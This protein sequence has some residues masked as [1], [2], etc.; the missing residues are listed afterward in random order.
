M[1]RSAL[2]G[3]IILGGVAAA[4]LFVPSL[5][6]T[7]ATANSPAAR[8]AEL[9]R[10][11]LH[12]YS[13]ELPH[14][15]DL[16]SEEQLK[17]ADLQA[18]IEKY[19]ETFAQA[20]QQMREAQQAAKSRDQ[21]AGITDSKYDVPN[22]TG[23][24]MKSAVDG[25]GKLVQLN[26]K[27][28]KDAMSLAKNAAQNKQVVG[29]SNVLG[30][31]EYTHAVQAQLKADDLRT[32]LDRQ[33]S[34][35]LAAASDWAV[36]N[37]LAE[38][39]AVESDVSK[40]VEALKADIANVTAQHAET[41]AKV[42]ELSKLTADREQQ[43]TGLRGDLAKS[44]EALAKIEQAGFKPGDDA[45]FAAYRDQYLKETENARALQEQEQTLSEGGQ[46]G[47]ALD[48]DAMIEGELVGGDAVIGL[49][50][51][52]R[53]LEIAKEREAR[54][55]KSKESLSA[56]AA[57]VEQAGGGAKKLN[58]DIA[59]QASKLRGDLDAKLK[60]LDEIVEAASGAA[61]EA[62]KA[63]DAAG[64][65]FRDGQ[66][67]V[68][69]MIGDARRTQQ[70][71]DPNRQNERLKRVLD[72][73]F[74]PQI[75]A[76]AEAAAKLLAARIHLQRYSAAQ[77]HE[78]YAAQLEQIGV[79]VAIDKE[80]QTAQLEGSRDAAAKALDEA[81]AGFERVSKGPGSVAWIPQSSMA[82]AHYL[83][84]QLDPSQAAAHR[85]RAL[86]DLTKV[87]EKRE[88]AAALAA[89]VRLRDHIT[90]Q[91]GGGE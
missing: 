51:L 78:A 44:R 58:Q 86:E 41:A 73:Q 61:E 36:T 2:L 90:A 67:A 34:D 71:L 8:D 33:Y 57:F 83:R 56:H 75:A 54:L 6:P 77:R 30:I 87:L 28:Y 39:Y 49:S 37:A 50:E 21:K 25:F 10:R 46:S 5:F 11:Q 42:A 65:A 69:N 1:N 62:A 43:L 3:L 72:D 85:A 40:T 31:A 76:S 80:K 12:R 48:E 9:A 68:D 66:S 84:A 63:A 55:A 35:V 32:Q 82:I 47:A 15:A 81:T 38:R 52:S 88:Q 74:L 53:R 20:Q 22:S 16:V 60:K 26:E 7:P 70:E 18:L 29:A 19:Q 91:G 89:Q 14:L 79:K 4:A 64:R 17:Q 27:L 13:P 59:A 24:A 23:A 45:S